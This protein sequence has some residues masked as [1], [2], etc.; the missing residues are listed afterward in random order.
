[1]LE[2]AVKSLIAYL[3]G[4]LVGALLLGRFRGVDIRKLGSGN[5]GSAN[6]L[7]T[8]GK[9]FA[10]GVVI[11]DVGKGWFSAA[12]LPDLSLAGITA[13]SLV[14]RAWLTMACATGA[15]LGHVYPV[16]FEFRGGKGAATLGGILLGLA[17]RLAL[18]VAVVWLAVVCT[19]GFVGLGTMCAAL[20]FPIAV[21]LNGPPRP[22]LLTFAIA[23][24]MFVV[25]THRGNVARMRAG[26][27][28]RARG[29]WLLRGRSAAR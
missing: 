29:L 11:V 2:L 9:L 16:W 13:D 10:L 25:Y 26:T 17:P 7:R 18:P 5:A 20:A 23:V 28:S 3:L 21:A 19:T 22:P 8:Q 4:S 24:A 15:M 12:V 6:A 14:D 1:M 27:E